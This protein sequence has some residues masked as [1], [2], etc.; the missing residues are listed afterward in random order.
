MLSLRSS[1]STET[2]AAA[3]VPQDSHS[4]SSPRVLFCGSCILCLMG[5][6]PQ[7]APSGAEEMPHCGEGLWTQRM[8]IRNMNRKGCWFLPTP[9]GIS[10][11]TWAVDRATVCAG[12]ALA[13]A[14]LRFWLL[15]PL[16][17]ALA[18]LGLFGVAE[19]R[20]IVFVCKHTQLFS[21]GMWLLL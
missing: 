21:A 9:S 3:G 5:K 10:C 16:S 17:Q 14:L 20:F 15:A 13:R 7:P 11:Q 4:V 6:V 2:D 19:Q 8:F 18:G 12:V 1:L